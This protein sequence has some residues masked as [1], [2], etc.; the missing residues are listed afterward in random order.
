MFKTIEGAADCGIRPVIRFF[1][2]RNVQPS[3]IHQICQGYGENA[4]S[5]GMVRNGFGCSMKDERSCTTRR[6]MGVHL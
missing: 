4:M 2:A 5:N 3:G 1:N 6:E